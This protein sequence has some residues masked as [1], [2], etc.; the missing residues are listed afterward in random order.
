MPVFVLVLLF[1][2]SATHSCK[3]NPFQLEDNRHESELITV[4]GD[5]PSASLDS[6]PN[7]DSNPPTEKPL[8]ND[9]SPN[10][11][12]QEQGNE[13]LD[14][15]VEELEKKQKELEDKQAELEKKQKELEDAWKEYEEK[16]KKKKKKKGKF[17]GLFGSCQKKLDA[18]Y[19]K[20][21]NLETVEDSDRS[22][23]DDSDRG[24]KGVQWSQQFWVRDSARRSR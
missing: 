20:A 22:Q 16:K 13:P 19:D 17:G 5:K 14:D 12:G 3:K 1:L 9:D 21:G 4:E 10:D 6:K 11:N 8:P 7:D 24:H 18:K 23:L 15:R 2:M